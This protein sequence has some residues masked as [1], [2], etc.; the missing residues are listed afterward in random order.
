M[1]TAYTPGPLLA[2]INNPSDLRVQLTDDQ[3][4]QLCQELRQYIVDIVSEKGG[5]FGAWV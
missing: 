3:L 5:H 2:K 1:S 4:P